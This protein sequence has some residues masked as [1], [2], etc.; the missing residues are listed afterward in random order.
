MHE[1]ELVLNQN[2]LL[3][4]HCEIFKIAKQQNFVSVRAVNM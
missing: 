1:I 3:Y 4:L 2:W